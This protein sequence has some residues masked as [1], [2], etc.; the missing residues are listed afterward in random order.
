MNYDQLQYHISIRKEEQKEW[1]TFMKKVRGLELSEAA[2][3]EVQAKVS[4][5]IVFCEKSIQD[6]QRLLPEALAI[7]S[8]KQA[9]GRKFNIMNDL[10]VINEM[11]Q[12]DSKGIHM[13]PYFV[14]CRTAPGGGHLTMGISAE[15]LQ[16]IVLNPDKYT[17]GLYVIDKKEFNEIKESSK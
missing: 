16:E 5:R 1:V 8:N 3:R 7:K 6:H 14:E 13:S 11:V 15:L 17:F 12:R 4:S 2:L 10:L 9:H